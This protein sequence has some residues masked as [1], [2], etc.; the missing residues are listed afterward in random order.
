M[1]KLQIRS[2]LHVWRPHMQWDSS[3]ALWGP[4]PWR[5][6]LGGHPKCLAPTMILAMLALDFLKVKPF[7][8]GSGIVLHFWT[9]LPNPSI[10]MRR[11]RNCLIVAFDMLALTWKYLL[12]TETSLYCASGAF[13]S[14]HRTHFLL[15]PGILNQSYATV[16]TLTSLWPSL[17]TVSYIYLNA[18]ITIHCQ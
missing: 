18:F 8:T 13:V 16:L 11:H 7:P 9:S 3:Y 10:F 14:G 15:A 6:G 12:R 4:E 5:V 2:M 1:L 17:S